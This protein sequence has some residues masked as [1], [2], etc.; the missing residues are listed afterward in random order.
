MRPGTMRS[1]GARRAEF[2]ALKRSAD[3]RDAESTGVGR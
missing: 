2:D 1:I 3:A